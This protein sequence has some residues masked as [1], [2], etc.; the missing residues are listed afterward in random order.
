MT[1]QTPIYSTLA[2]DCVLHEIVEMFIHELPDRVEM[3]LSQM[4]AADWQ[5]LRRTAH[6]LKGA[7]GSYG[8]DQLTPAA[9]KLEQ[10]L[11][12]DDAVTRVDDALDELIGLCRRVQTGHA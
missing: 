10:I 1:E 7:L 4:Q 6:Q 8:L 5:G 11:Q 9:T 12:A 3:L 2:N